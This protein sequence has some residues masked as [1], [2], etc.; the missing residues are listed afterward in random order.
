[1]NIDKDII[2]RPDH[3]NAP[4]GCVLVLPGRG[5]SAGLMERF[6]LHTGLW[7]S[8]KVILEPRNL[9]WYPQP[10]G[11]EDQA[12]ALWGQNKA[13]QCLE[14]EVKRIERG[15]GITKKDICI[16]GF[17]AGS[18]MAIQMLAYSDQPYAGILSLAGAI[19][20]PADLPKGK[21][22]TPV[23]LQHNMDDDCF[24]WEERYLPM[25][26][27]LIEKGYNVQT[28]EGF[29]GGHNLTGEEVD[30]T[31]SFVAKRFGYFDDFEVI[32]EPETVPVEVVDETTSSVS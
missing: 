26:K 21:F 19:L 3:N 29:D 20:K 8:L 1:M 16:V 11:P 32:E 5:L 9:E 22:D 24:K 7:R 10:N 27:A 18:V 12:G 14:D 30:L 17:S 13:R 4:V 25:K 15:W 6:M 28:K 23:M 2:M 31:R